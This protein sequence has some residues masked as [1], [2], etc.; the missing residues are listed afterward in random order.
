MY[1]NKIKHDELGD[2]ICP[3]CCKQI[4]EQSVKNIECC[5][6]QCLENRDHEIVSI[7]CR[8]IDGFVPIQELCSFH[9]DKHK[10]V[11][12]SIYYRKYLLDKIIFNL[13]KK[14]NIMIT[15]N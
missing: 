1:C 4:K 15:T 9:D 5:D 8:Q 3:F 10:M 13:T 2:I 12:K 14:Y 7:N 11:R 6:E